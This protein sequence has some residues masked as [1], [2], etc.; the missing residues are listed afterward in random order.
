MAKRSKRRRLPSSVPANLTISVEYNEDFTT[1]FSDLLFRAYAEWLC[2]ED[3]YLR[4]KLHKGTLPIPLNYSQEWT[5]WSRILRPAIKKL[6][7]T[8]T[9]R[10]FPKPTKRNYQAR[11][12][13]LIEQLVSPLEQEPAG[14]YLWNGKPLTQYRLI[15]LMAQRDDTLSQDTIRKY[16]RHWF[17]HRKLLAH[18]PITKSER[19]FMRQ[20]P[21][22][23]KKY[24]NQ[25]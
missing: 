6:W 22:R 11:C 13:Q 10:G 23:R 12:Y 3:G 14:R 7:E 1:F 24:G 15:Q 2:T 16:A 4:P 20:N 8:Y 18:Q 19:T 17:I 25:P 9:E 5:E 21:H